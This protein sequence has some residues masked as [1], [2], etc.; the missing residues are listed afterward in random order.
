VR[1]H[2]KQWGGARKNL[3]GR[4]LNGRLYD[5]MPTRS[6]VPVLRAA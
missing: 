4:R 5:E 1:E 6:S 3:T 2:D